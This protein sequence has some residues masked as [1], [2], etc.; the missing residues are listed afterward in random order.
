MFNVVT[1]TA[2]QREERRFRDKPEAMHYAVERLT[3]YS[4]CAS[5]TIESKGQI[6]FHPQDIQRTFETVRP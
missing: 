5:V 4:G 1:Q 6:V 3:F 2:D